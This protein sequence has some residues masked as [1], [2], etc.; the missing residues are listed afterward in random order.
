MNVLA[1]MSL[2]GPEAS[3][4]CVERGHEYD[5]DSSSSRREDCEQ[6]MDGVASGL[7]LVA[8]GINISKTTKRCCDDYRGAQKQMLRAQQQGQQFQL[9]QGLIDELPQFKKERIGPAQASLK[10]VQASL[11]TEIHLERKRDHLK[12]ALGRKS[13][14][15]REITQYNQIENSLSLNLLV[16]HS[17]D[18]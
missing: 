11:P 3:L 4:D 16:S 12:W 17:Q 5:L 10:D 15:E 7:T 2:K 13:K 8:A 1:Y 14:I 9:N 18:M 6:V